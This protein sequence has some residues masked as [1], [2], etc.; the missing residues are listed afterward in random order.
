MK[1]VLVLD[2]DRAWL[3]DYEKALC[4]KVLALSTR[5]ISETRQRFAE[6]TDIAVIVLDGRLDDP[7]SMYSYALATELRRQFNG[8]MIA[9]SGSKEYREELIRAGCDHQ[10]EKADVPNLVLKL[11]TD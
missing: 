6:H 10:S 1:K 2:D 8:P 4:G 11:L 3:E 7:E 9:A 5:L